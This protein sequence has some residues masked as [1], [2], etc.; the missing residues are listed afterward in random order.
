MQDRHAY[1]DTN[2]L[3]EN[4]TDDMSIYDIAKYY[5][6]SNGTVMIIGSFTEDGDKYKTCGS[7]VVVASTGYKTSTLSGQI[8]ASMGSYIAT[9]Y[10][11]IDFLYNTVYSGKTLEVMAENEVKYPCSVLWADK[12]LDVA[13]LYADVSYNYIK[14]VDRWVDCAGKDKLDLEEVFT[15]GTPV[16]TSV[17]I[18]QY[19]NRFT[20]GDV[21]SDNSITMAT[22]Q[23]VYAYSNGNDMEYSY[24][25]DT[26][27]TETVVLDNVYEGIIDIAVGISG[28][29]SGGGCFDKK[30][31]LIGLA[32]LGTSVSV[33]DGNQM[34]GAVP[35][36]P[37]MK[38][39]DKLIANKE[40]AANY[41]IYS[42][43]SL[44]LIGID[45]TEAKYARLVKSETKFSHYFVNGKFYNGTYSGL[46]EFSDEGYCVLTNRSENATI[47]NNIRSGEII[48]SCQVNGGAARKIT[49]RNDLL[50]L[51][52]DLDQGDTLTIN[53]ET[54]T[55]LIN[56]QKSVTVTL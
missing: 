42:I 44:G 13:V 55:L 37:I 29:N 28:G 14:M 19:L 53:Y 48:K 30:G 1:S 6:D 36:Y 34:N 40:T 32:T 8:T 45:S 24:Q 20:R 35:I 41:K 9:N 31:N 18:E 51:L 52:L 46:F 23:T 22:G 39:L 56:M 27:R 33:T 16:T 7:G 43:E 5:R 38:V 3:T 50:Y 25:D 10:H 15:I 2:C 54:T 4:L 12:N 49:D 26:G 21:A 47:A 17:N 11:V